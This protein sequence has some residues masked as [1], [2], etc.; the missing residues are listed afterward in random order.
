MLGILFAI[1]LEHRLTAVARVVIDDNE[2]V[3]VGGAN[4]DRD[5]LP[6]NLHAFQIVRAWRA[7][8]FRFHFGYDPFNGFMSQRYVMLWHSCP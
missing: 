3:R 1:V 8:T 5:T 2:P 4:P 6:D 7:V